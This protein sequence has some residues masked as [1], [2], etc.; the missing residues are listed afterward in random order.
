MLAETASGG[1]GH[2]LGNGSQLI[3]ERHRE[4]RTRRQIDDAGNVALA[5]KRGSD[6]RVVP[7]S[8]W[9]SFV[10]QREL[11][12]LRP[13][14]NLDNRIV[15]LLVRRGGD[16]VAGG[17]FYLGLP[18]DKKAVASES[19]TNGIEFES[20]KNLHGMRHVTRAGVQGNGKIALAF[21]FEQPG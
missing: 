20:M 11:K 3:H 8:F 13:G 21:E 9:K 6:A 1:K 7:G 5:F 2:R 10:F 19:Q 15:I 4:I 18:G 17:D 12:Y 16:H 14:T